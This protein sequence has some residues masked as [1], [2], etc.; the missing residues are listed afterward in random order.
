MSHTM[1]PCG[2]ALRCC[3]ALVSLLFVAGP[4]AT[5][6]Q[7]SPVAQPVPGLEGIAT[8]SIRQITRDGARI[9]VG[10]TPSGST[11]YTLVLDTRTGATVFD[12]R[13]IQ[14]T[15]RTYRSALLSPDGLFLV[16]SDHRSISV[17]RVRNLSTGD[18]HEAF[19]DA[20]GDLEIRAVADGATTVATYSGFGLSAGPVV[21]VGGPGNAYHGFHASN[22]R[23]GAIQ[24][25]CARDPVTMNADG[26]Y[27]TYRYTEASAGPAAPH[28]GLLLADVAA[29]RTRVLPVVHAEL[30]PELWAAEPWAV[31]I[32]GEGHWIGFT[33]RTRTDDEPRAALVHR[34]TDQ[35]VIVAATLGRTYFHDVSD[36][37][38]FVLLTGEY[39]PVTG[40]RLWVV[41]RLSGIVSKVLDPLDTPAGRYRVLSAQLSGDGS[42]I[43]ATL[44]DGS[45][46]DLFAQRTFIARLDTDGDGL[47]DAWETA[48]GLNPA[49]ASDAALDPDDDGR[50]NA[51]EYQEG[52]HPRGTPVRYFA[53]GADGTFFSTSV[54]LFNPSDAPVLVNVRFLGPD[55]ARM[56]TPVQLPARSPAYLDAGSLGLPF[57]EFSIVVESPGP[58]AVERRMTWDRT[59]VYGSHGSTGVASPALTWHFAEGAT[60]GG[61][62]TF[63]LLQNPGTTPAHVTMR[64]WLSNG[65]AETR[66][67]VVP[68][69][70]RLT[71]WA[72]E[73]GAPLDAAEFA[74]KIE[75][76]V[77]VVAERAVYRDAPRQTFG[78]GSVAS[79]VAAPDVS[80]SFA[81]GATGPYFDTFLLLANP[82]DVTATADVR[83]RR[84]GVHVSQDDDLRHTYV[85]APH[86]RRTVWVDQ[87]DTR[88][89]DTAFSSH[90]TADVPILAERAM[91][92][93]GPTSASWHGSH[94]ETGTRAGTMWAI[95]DVE[96]GATP[97]VDTF[98]CVGSRSWLGAGLRITLR[99][100]DGTSATR[101]VAVDDRYTLWPRHDFPESIGRRF[102][103]TIES[104]EVLL[105]ASPMLP[106]GRV[107]LVVEKATYRGE[108]EA[109]AGSLGTRLPDPP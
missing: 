70:S 39:S 8:A 71:V 54:A 59:R 97:E 66:V 109:G 107:P 21:V 56:V 38:R 48:F 76:D 12:S 53:E 81:E 77:P 102:A 51:Q 67:H 104:L 103:V 19:R 36:D 57:S 20:F 58:L 41:D 44:G 23:P 17:T 99:F 7:T 31:K 63:F 34:L 22:C 60:I 35:T 78:A 18:E 29:G 61:I 93:P 16:D 2:T 49:D 15:G 80:W 106:R 62:Q 32:S 4:P 14:T 46:S 92:W 3:A 98:I 108:F 87:E 42:T 90:V 6:A 101:D 75:A 52:T 24:M 30:G 83:F 33:G 55:G 25:L 27:L 94:V 84:A 105:A 47:H 95:A 100:D 5:M 69:A 86:S 91:W 50:S 96:V 26:A 72:N 28:H 9:V 73:E 74:T 82:G 88:L 13:P 37:A 1:A 89:A 40:Q 45:T 85:L 68:P 10:V 79:G 65:A 64:Y 11:A 43:V